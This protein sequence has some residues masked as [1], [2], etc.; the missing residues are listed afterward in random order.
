MI[1]GWSIGADRA[2]LAV[3]E[4]GAQLSQVRFTLADGRT[5]APMHTAPWADEALPA[6]TPPVLRMLRGDF[7]C[8]P[9]GDSDV[10]ADETRGHGRP[11]NGTWRVTG[12]T[13]TAL[14]IAL[15]GDVMGAA[16]TARIDVRPGHSVVYQRHVLTG[17]AGRLPLGHHAMLRAEPPLLLGFSPWR[18]A[19]TP[20]APVEVPP[21]G[22]SL[23]AYP[24]VISDPRQ[25]RRADGGRVDLTRYPVA[26]GHED[27]WMLVAAADQPFAWSAATASGAGWVWFAL[28]DPRLLPATTLWLSDGGRSYAP[29]LSR[30]RRVI[31]I[32]EVAGYF[33][34]GH[35]ASTGDNPLAR[36]GIATAATLRPE[37]PLAIPYLFGVAA[38]PADFGAVATIRPAPGGVTLADAAGHSGFAALDLSHITHASDRDPP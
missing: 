13:A 37:T 11:A 22:R 5:V 26:E 28:K 8:A 35:A 7:F 3:T 16:V 30:H 29:W 31:G 10:L 24:Q 14:D 18:W 38:V 17:G 15:D 25:A 9:F 20:E 36:Q 6:D 21:A 19:G 32:E 2:A 4:T 23:L 27:I 34:L 33:H 12:Q 1:A